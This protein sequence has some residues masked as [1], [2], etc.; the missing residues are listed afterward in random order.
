M[1]RD[2]S[3][4]SM[5]LSRPGGSEPSSAITAARTALRSSSCEAAIAAGATGEPGA[6]W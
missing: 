6:G 2:F 1:D 3:T 5:T 4:R